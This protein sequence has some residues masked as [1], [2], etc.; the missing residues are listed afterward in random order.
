MTDLIL[1]Q[2]SRRKIEELPPLLRGVSSSFKIHSRPALAK[3]IS[4]NFHL[5]THFFILSS[6]FNIMSP[7]MFVCS[8]NT[9]LARCMSRF[10]TLCIVVPKDKQN[11]VGLPYSNLPKSQ[12]FMRRASLWQQSPREE[13]RHI[14][15]LIP[16]L[17]SHQLTG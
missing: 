11:Q 17:K 4:G 8:I 15:S 9:G 3:P 7:T 6:K 2:A 13:T 16:F 10:L 12:P 5:L 14:T 1:L